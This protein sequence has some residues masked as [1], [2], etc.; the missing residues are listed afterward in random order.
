[1]VK[2]LVRSVPLSEAI[3][4]LMVGVVELGG[5]GGKPE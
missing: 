2:E 1:M 3:V 4:A 5:K